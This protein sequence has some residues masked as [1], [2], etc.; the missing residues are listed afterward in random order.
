[1]IVDPKKREI[2]WLA[3]CGDRYEPI[4]RSSLIDFGSAEL[5]ERIVWA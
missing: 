2:H 5:A 3:L 4:E 1:L